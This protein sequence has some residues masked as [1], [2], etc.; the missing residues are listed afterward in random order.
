MK[1]LS[2]A[3][4]GRLAL[5][6]AAIIWGSSF[7]IM[8]DTLD[9]IPVFQLLAIR[10]TLGGLLLAL[11]F[12]KRLMQSGAATLRHGAVCAVFLLAAYA[13]QTYG[14]MTTSPGT[15]A[16]LTA[17][18]CVMVPFMAW[19]LFRKRPT[20]YNWAAAVMCVA[21]IGLISLSGDLALGAG[22]LLTLL[23]GFLYAL[24]I[25]CLSRFGESD[26]PIALT[27][28]QFAGVAVLSWIFTLTVE[29]GS[30]L[31]PPAVWPHLLYLTIFA[32]A[33]TL[34]CQSVGQSLTPPNQS[35][36]LLSLES[37]FGVFFSVLMG[38]ENLTVQLCLGFTLVFV[39][40]IV[41]ETQLSFLRHSKKT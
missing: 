40:V 13:T 41:S 1:K 8:K 3:T 34:V 26:D 24:H 36:I 6:T 25:M 12:R 31:P 33:V 10:F 7:I 16:F 32:T 20:A 30:P 4:G 19:G 11:V 21:G 2:N 39:S 28:V 35:A 17:V 27:I 37:V 29:A 14:L 9:A 23:S 38:R 15:N 18:Y 22:E 5:L